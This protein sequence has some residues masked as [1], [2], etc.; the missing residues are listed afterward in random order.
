MTPKIAKKRILH[1]DD[2]DD[3]LKIVKIILENEG[4]EVTSASKGKEALKKVN[5]NNFA[6]II[7]DVMMPDM[8]GWDLFTRIAK[9][10]P[11]YKVIFLSILDISEEKIKELENNG[12]KD[13]IKKPFDNN[14]LVARVKKVINS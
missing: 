13:Y 10:K 9:I 14:D 5:L 11:D 2:N 8:S 6:L 3:T 7:L 1:V 4:F 12:I